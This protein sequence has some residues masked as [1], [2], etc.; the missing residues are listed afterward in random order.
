MTRLRKMMLEELH[1]VITPGL[2]R[3][4]SVVFG[5]SRRSVNN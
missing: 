4:V 3:L 2:H 5:P 1:V